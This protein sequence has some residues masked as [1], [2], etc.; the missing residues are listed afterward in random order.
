MADI[1]DASSLDAVVQD[2]GAVFHMAAQVAVTTSLVEPIADFEVNVHATLG[3]L[4]AVRRT[5]RRIPLVFASTNKVYGDLGDLEMRL[6][7]E[8]YL[9][10]DPVVRRSGV[11]ET[12]PLAF[13]A[14]LGT[15]WPCTRRL[16]AGEVPCALFAFLPLDPNSEVQAIHPKAMPVVLTEASEID[17][18]LQ[19]PWSEAGALQRPLPDGALRIVARGQ[20]EDAPSG[21]P[22]NASRASATDMTPR[23]LS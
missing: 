19:A 23:L 11:A 12:R 20:K 3:L 14:G 17:T 8:A 15:S 6:E 1:R 18:W 10:V 16:A 22:S 5:G 2:A 7:G 4:E 21:V 9:P 13:F